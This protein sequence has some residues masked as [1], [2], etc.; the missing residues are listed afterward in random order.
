MFCLY[1]YILV[2]VYLIIQC[3]NAVGCAMSRASGM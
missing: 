1:I 3:S 2:R